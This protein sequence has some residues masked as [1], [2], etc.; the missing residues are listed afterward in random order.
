VLTYEKFAGLAL[1]NPH[2]LK[3]LS[4]VIIDEVQT[5]VDPGRGA[6][7]EFLL[8][9]L[10]ARRPEG[11]APQIVALSAVL[12]D[13]SG[14]DSWLDANVIARTERPVPLLEGVLG[15]DG[16]YRHVDAVG[17]Q[18]FVQLI[19]P[20]GWMQRNQDLI[21]PLVRKLV[22]EGQQV[23][24]FRST[25]PA[26]LGRVR[27][28]PADRLWL[29]ALSRLV[30]RYQQGEVFTVARATLL[31]WHRRLVERKWNYTSRSAPVDEF[32]HRTG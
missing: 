3:L 5:I 9:L 19:A 27:Y 7:L 30:P 4:V 1:G 15:P 20:T 24:I 13:L 10:K 16:I 8:T 31:A 18:A 2:L 28:E 17:D 22:G 6:Y 25:R 12:G 23:I 11:V 29:A 21:I 14:L 26:A 32:W